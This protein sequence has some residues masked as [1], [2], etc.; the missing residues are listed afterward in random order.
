MSA[1][2]P[3]YSAEE[4]QRR[5]TELYE[6][7]IRPRVEEGNKGKVVAIDIDTGEFEMDANPS[8]ACQRLTARLPEAQIWCVRIGYRAMHRWLGGRRVRKS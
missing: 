1:R 6:K 2:E 3:K 8:A 4:F 7:T 5:G